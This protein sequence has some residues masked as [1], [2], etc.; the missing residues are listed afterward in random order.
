[1]SRL[2]VSPRPRS[3]TS[4]S[5][6]Q[7]AS[8]TACPL[9]PFRGRR[10]PHTPDLRCPS[11]PPFLF[12]PSF[13]KTPTL[14]C[15]VNLS[16]ACLPFAAGPETFVRQGAPTRTSLLPWA[17]WRQ[18]LQSAP[19]HGPGG[20]AAE[21]QWSWLCGLP[22]RQSQRYLQQWRRGGLR[23]GRVIPG[24]G[25]ATGGSDGISMVIVIMIEAAVVQ[26]S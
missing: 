8:V 14:R 3:G 4:V 18:C 12:P 9:V 5:K 16:E 1:V 6:R 10:S 17:V 25:A 22:A 7:P 23:N 21:P 26:L 20:S 13:P 2:R 11:V 24:T 19:L 15:R